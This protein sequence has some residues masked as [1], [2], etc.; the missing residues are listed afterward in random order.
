MPVSPWVTVELH[1]STTPYALVDSNSAAL[2]QTGAGT[3]IFTKAVSGTSYYIAV[4]SRNTITTWSASPRS[5]ISSALSYNFTTAM[6]QAYTNRSNPPL[7]LHNGKYCIYSGDINLDG[8]VTSDDFTGVD[9][10][11]NKGDYH[12]ENDLNGDGFVTSADDQF[13]DNNNTHSIQ[14]QVP[15]GAQ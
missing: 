2:N 7:A 13:I 10:D 15:T 12:I 5:F 8:F 4:K 11:A 9:N 6:T 14:R 3:F 1:N